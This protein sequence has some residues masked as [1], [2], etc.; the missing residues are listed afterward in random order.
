MNSSENVMRTQKRKKIDAV[1]AFGGCCCICGYDK[2]I[3]ALE[4]HHLDKSTKEETPSHV[5]MKWKWDR[6]VKELEKCILVCANCHREIHAKETSDKDLDLYNYVKPW[7]KKECNY[8]TKEFKTKDEG[9]K[10]C[11]HVCSTYSQRKVKHPTKEELSE[12]IK[13]TNWTQLGKMFG[14]SDNAVRNWAKRY[15]II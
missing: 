7:L 13:T 14:V 2:C 5:I 6:V 4:F 8:C 9:Q 12:L 3:N 1:N 15:K 11:S 10:F